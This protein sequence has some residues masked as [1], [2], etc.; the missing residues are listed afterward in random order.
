MGGRARFGR[1]FVPLCLAEW[2]EDALEGS[3]IWSLLK[4]LGKGCPLWFLQRCLSASIKSMEK[5]VL[6][7]EELEISLDTGNAYC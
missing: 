5:A 2:K 7:D 1:F 4:I 6:L 3:L